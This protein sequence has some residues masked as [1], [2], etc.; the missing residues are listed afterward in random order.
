MPEETF[1]TVT[2]VATR[3]KVHPVSV[4]RFIKDGRLRV[5]RLG[6]GHKAAVRVPESALQEFLSSQ[7][8]TAQ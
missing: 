3:L 5:V 4:R 8:E 1:Y 6:H 2:E 7:P